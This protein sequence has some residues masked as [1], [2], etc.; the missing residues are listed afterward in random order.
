MRFNLKPKSLK[1]KLCLYFSLIAIVPSLCIVLFYYFYSTGLLKQTMISNANANGAYIIN[2]MDN[3]LQMAENLSDW[4]FLNKNFAN[5]VNSRNL[6][7]SALY[8]KLIDS[9]QILNDEVLSSSI[10]KDVSVI[11]ISGN[12][13]IDFRFGD[14][15]SLIDKK[16]VMKTQFFKESMDKKGIIYFPGI[17]R[18]PNKN[19]LDQYIIPIVRP[20]LD[21][22]FEKSIGWSFIGFKESL[23]SDV[24]KELYKRSKDALYVID[25]KGTCISSSEKQYIGKSMS[26]EN[27]IVQLLSKNKTGYYDTSYQGKDCL[28]VFTKSKITGWNLVQ[29][30]SYASLFEQRAVLFR[31]AIIISLT[32]I[33]IMVIFTI[34]LSSNLTNPL[35]KIL[36]RIRIISQGNFERDPS[37][38]G[39][40]EM[41]E[42]G[43]GINELSGNIYK[44]LEKVKEEEAEK[45]NLELQVLQNQVNPHFLYNTLNSIKWMATVQ[46]ADGIKNIVSALGRLLMNISKDS[47]EEISIKQELS[48]TDDYIFIQNIRYNGKIKQEYSIADENLLQ[49]KIVKFTLQPI[50]ENAIF[51]GIEPKKE[52]G[53]IKIEIAQEL[54]NIIILI[55]DDGVG[56]D[57]DSIKTITGQKHKNKHKGLSGIGIKNVDERL[58]LFYGENYGLSIE[59]EVGEYTKVI[60]KIPKT[61]N[62]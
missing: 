55:M 32:T 40:G 56:I 7:G 54:E 62:E 49:N 46:K 3:R 24:Y 6:K 17:V 18:N 34:Y 43:R 25:D 22:T 1:M 20:V 57:E 14:N 36:K 60:V 59:S 51:H 19:T 12:G 4:I 21:S 26:G 37:L 11:I 52:A 48:L 5:A 39:E 28:I 47:S 10:V 35:R 38:E 29:R 15:A 50:V 41:G 33:L 44:L 30:I 2:N 27:F 9:Q 42:L 23:I 45:R 61:N 8:K 31:M 58:K 13:D 16:A 53:S